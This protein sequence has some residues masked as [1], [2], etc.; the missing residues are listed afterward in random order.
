[1]RIAVIDG[2]SCIITPISDLFTKSF[3]QLA[4]E[5]HTL[6]AHFNLNDI[7]STGSPQP[8]RLQFFTAINTIEKQEALRQIIR[9][10]V[11]K[12]TDASLGSEWVVLYMAYLYATGKNALPKRYAHFFRDLNTL[13][14]GL[15]TNLVSCHAEDSGK[16][17]KR[18]TDSLSDD[19]PN[20]FVINGTL[21]P[22]NEWTT[23]RYPNV[24]KD[25]RNRIQQLVI[26][27]YNDLIKVVKIVC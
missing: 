9:N 20:W 27:A 23:Y 17:Y 11:N 2:V 7:K 26:H 5:F 3:H 25:R 15:L 12:M 1:M 4:G 14:P 10:L 13:L 8:L 19:C 6:M 18:Y 16:R 21:P 22:I 24:G